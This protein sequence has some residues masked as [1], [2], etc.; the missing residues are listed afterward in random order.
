[1]PNS[2]LEWG[3]DLIIGLQGFGDWLVAP[4]NLFTFS[5]KCGILPAYS[6]RSV[7]VR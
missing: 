1:M 6:S 2:V 3:I 7:L 4:L 5:G